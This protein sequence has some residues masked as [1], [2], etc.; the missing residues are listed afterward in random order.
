[1]LARCGA[2]VLIV[3]VLLWAPPASAGGITLRGPGQVAPIDVRVAVGSSAPKLHWRAAT[4]GVLRA[5]ARRKGYRI[6]ASLVPL[7]DGSIE[8]RA[9]IRYRH[10]RRVWREMVSVEATGPAHAVDRALAYSPVRGRARVDRGTPA[11]VTVGDLLIVP[12]LGAAATAVQQVGERHRVSMIAFDHGSHPRRVMK[13]CGNRNRLRAWRRVLRIWRRAGERVSIVARLY[14]LRP[15]SSS[16]PLIVERWA[17]GARAAIAFTDHAD[18]TD[19]EALRALLY[20][21]S[22]I[23]SPRYGKGG[24][25]GHGLRITKTFFVRGRHGALTS[26]RAAATLADELATRGSEVALHSIGRAT[27]SRH[28]VLRGLESVRRWKPVT[29]VDHQPHTNCEALSSQG[30]NGRRRWRVA[31]LL[32]KAGYRWVWAATEATFK[33]MQLNLFVPQ[34]P[35]WAAPALFPLAR[36][37]QL[38][39]FRTNWFHGTPR[40]LEAAM[41]PARLAAL[42]RERG[43]FVG[44]SYLS[45]SRRT[46]VRAKYQNTHVA[47][48]RGHFLELH[49]RFESVLARLGARVKAGS[50][51]SLTFAEVGRRLLAVSHVRA[52]YRADGTVALTNAGATTIHG[53]TIAIPDALLD[54]WVDRRKLRV[55]RG[56]GRAT[57]WFDLPAGRTAIVSA[58][59]NGRVV[60]L[61]NRVRATPIIEP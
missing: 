15:R 55:R 61:V 21:T 2:G 30:V 19:P 31:D 35:A 36:Y 13:R 39:M 1:V 34:R 41:S 22:D 43:L 32:V 7:G 59:R 49:P 38:W 48:L 20:G 9:T 27:D 8:L 44:H 6:A 10:N 29:W 50:L 58:R 45:T 24:F 4:G 18:R 56:E 26:N 28:A 52:H 37:P 46:T 16:M 42:E 60:P 17:A 47:R 40:E 33:P 23:R 25:F 5:I 14:L 3:G 11:F 12:E 54:L 57:A 53:L 51:A